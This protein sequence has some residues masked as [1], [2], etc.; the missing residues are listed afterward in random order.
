MF[1]GLDEVTEADNRR[2]RL[3]EA[4][5][6]FCATM[7]KETCVLVTA[8]P[9]AYTDPKWQLPRFKT[10]TLL[11][12]NEEQVGRFVERWYQAMREVMNGMRT[13]R[14]TRRKA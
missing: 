7:S 6:A 8:R 12:F 13:P 10:L 3:I 9:Y 11:P 14:T 4:I 5:N 2:E 1:D